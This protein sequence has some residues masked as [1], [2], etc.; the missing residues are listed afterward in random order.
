MELR[1]SFVMKNRVVNHEYWLVVLLILMWTLLAIIILAINTN[2]QNLMPPTNTV[3]LVNTNPPPVIEDGYTIDATTA[4]QVCVN[5][6][7]QII[8]VNSNGQISI[9]TEPML[10]GPNGIT[11]VIEYNDVKLI[12]HSLMLAEYSTNL[13]TWQCATI[14]GTFVTCVPKQQQEFFK[15]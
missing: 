4:T 15:P 12:R 7:N 3:A 8:C 5:A 11:E 10:T 14:Y 1:G 6:D 9:G 13:L 2:G